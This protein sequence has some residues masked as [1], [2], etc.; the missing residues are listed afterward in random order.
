MTQFSPV[1]RNP[2]IKPKGPRKLCWIRNL[3]A[4]QIILSVLG[5]NRHQDNRSTYIQTDANGVALNYGTATP[6]IKLGVGHSGET[7]LQMNPELRSAVFLPRPNDGN[8]LKEMRFSL[9][10]KAQVEYDDG[11][12]RTVIVACSVSADG[13]ENFSYGVSFVGLQ[14]C[15][16][17][18][19]DHKKALEKAANV[20]RDLKEKNPR[21]EDLSNFYRTASPEN[22][23]KFGGKLWQGL[24][25]KFN[26]SWPAPRDDIEREYL[27]T[28]EEADRYFTNKITN[29]TFKADIN[30]LPRLQGGHALLGVYAGKYAIFE[31]GVHSD[32]H[33]GGTN[34]PKEKLNDQRYEITMHFR[35]RNT[36]PQFKH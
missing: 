34:I 22:L 27:F 2:C 9:N 35:L 16:S 23:E 36:S 5:C 13:D 15:D 21:I 12:T 10:S 17:P 24:A 26:D 4:I 32:P 28:F 25:V 14:L 30:D 3:I 18:I 19:N 20:I 11:D 7:F 33:W 6:V 8:I 31:I 1:E 29:P